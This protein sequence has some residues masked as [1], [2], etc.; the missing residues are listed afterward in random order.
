MN[1]SIIRY[2][3]NATAM[4]V[5]GIEKMLYAKQADERQ[6]TGRRMKG[7]FFRQPVSMR[8][9]T[10]SRM[11]VTENVIADILMNGVRLIARSPEE[12]CCP[13]PPAPCLSVHG[14]CG[15]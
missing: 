1:E 7:S 2:T 10:P 15:R 13:C 6:S 9:E 3:P 11:C 12:G 4:P 8:N 14:S 5:P